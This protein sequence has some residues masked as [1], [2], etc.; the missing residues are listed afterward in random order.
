[1]ARVRRASGQ[2]A[3]ALAWGA[4]EQTS[5]MTAAMSDAD[6]QRIARS[7]MPPLK[8]AE[9]LALFDAGS[10][11]SDAFLLP[12]R[13]DLPALRAQG[14]PP[15][16]LR[17]LIKTPKRRAAAQSVAAEGL[18]AELSRLGPDARLDA[19]LNLVATEVAAVLG[20]GSASEVDRTRTFQGLGFDSLTAVELRNRLT[21]STGIRLPATL[22]FD[23]PTAGALASYLLDELFGADV[24]VPE[25]VSDNV[26]DDPIVIVGMACR[27]PGGVSSP[28]D[29]WRL[30]FEE[31][32]GVTGFPENRGWDLD[33]L[34]DSDPDAAGKTHVMQGGFLYDAPS[35]DPDFFGMSPREAL[36]TDVQHRLL[37][38]TAWEAFERAGI[39]PASVRGSK[40]GVFAGVMS[41]DYSTLVSDDIFE[42]YQGTGTAQ[43][44]LSG[45]VA[46]T[47]G[48][49]GPAVTVD[50][51]CSSSLVALHLASS[52]LRNGEC[53]LALA[54]GV[55]VMSTPGSFV[56]FSKQRGL[57]MDGRCKSFADAADGTGWGEG[58]GLLVLERQ[59]DALRNG[60]TILAVVRGSAVNQDGASN[61]LTAPNG[62][63][64]QRVIRSALASA[65]LSVA[66]VDV[67]EAHGTGT[68][69]G[70]PIE[71]Q[72][73]LAVYGQDR[74]SPLLLGSIKSNIGHT[75]AAAG[76][77]GIIKM[78]HAMRHGVVPATLHVDQPST[79]IDWTAGDVSLVTTAV[80]WPNVS[81]SR[82]AGVSSFG[83]SGTN[84][85]V[86][87]E[88]PELSD[89]PEMIGMGG[90]SPQGASQSGSIPL[91][92]SAR[93]AD[94]LAAQVE[95]I[96]AWPGDA[97]DIAFSLLTTRAVFDHRAVVL[98]GEVLASGV[99]KAGELA[100][101]FSGQG[102]QRIGMGRALYEAFPVFAEGLDAVLANL[103]PA[104]REVMWGDDQET[105]NQTGYTQPA[106][107]AFQVALYRLF[108]FYGVKPDHIAGHSIG[109]IA[110]AHV[111]GV[112]SL[113]DACQL[114][115]ARASLMQALP[116]G[117]AM[118]SVV[119]SE[120]K[121]REHLTDGVS[122]AVVN[123]PR[124]VVIAGVEEEV[125][126]IAQKWKNKRLKVSH[127]FHSPLMQPML[128]DF[129]EAI[130]GLTF[131][132]PVVQMS[133]SGDVTTVDY[134]V[135]HVRDTVRFHENVTRLGDVKFLE[136]GPDGVL[137]AMV[138]GCVP[139]VRR[140]VD[141][142]KSMLTALSRINVDGVNV[143]WNRFC[144]HGRKI[145]LPTYAFEQQTFWPEVSTRSDVRSAGLGAVG[146]PLFGAAVELAG[147][148]GL[149]FTSRLSLRTH[150]WLRDHSLHGK[151]LV[152][153]AALVEL[154][155]RA[156]DEVGLDRLDELTIAAPLV[157]PE[158]GAVQVQI[159][160]G[161]DGDR[162]AVTIHSRPEDSDLP[163]TEHAAGFLASGT[164][165]LDFD[166]SEWPPAGAEAVQVEGVYE[167]FA[168]LGFDYGHAFRG[169]RAA[170]KLGDQVF[171]EVALPEDV[172]V[173]GFGL[174]PALL[175]AALH[176]VRSRT[177]G[178]RARCRSRGKALH[179][180]RWGP[181]RCG[182]VSGPPATARWRSPSPTPPVRRSRRSGRW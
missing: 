58:V 167:R 23:Y 27:Y 9:G 56:A 50:T 90:S 42:G 88:A 29:L 26:S 129:R 85:H 154:A 114:V 122:I 100:F 111:A 161:A 137:S 80:S 150:P 63:S 177:G 32:D 55:T 16:L 31:R 144:Q 102:S 87:L 47:F 139:A 97:A 70:D 11:G 4:W 89:L 103:D 41:N 33:S 15:P 148:E 62:P 86:I 6:L 118:V 37:L 59:S 104:V 135:N 94:S 14:A 182:C 68:T 130:S 13:L 141:E 79:H 72:A 36:A 74:P 145:D 138:D 30:V 61:G 83:V 113:E 45:R 119:A 28:E 112:L 147:G 95:R 125:L 126:A 92:V 124:S 123:G 171:A 136:I 24:L 39:D 176:A 164:T 153:G 109:E 169:L 73:L 48:L 67:V 76:V 46:Y 65:G 2:H 170:W 82:R 134:W 121:V 64:Q 96:K 12:L 142:V 40:T 20:H 91:V 172:T 160:V 38:Q 43:S 18:V 51:A 140:N 173:A 71:A 181:R 17:G 110:A 77:A 22:I 115:T 60:H 152:P 158:T 1:M 101:L 34:Y 156:A 69:L 53:S 120:K 178:P 98:D 116:A 166:A 151:V 163:W 3:V 57:A 99:A 127:A 52:A 168:E 35:F 66:D 155:L 165:T 179:C 78:V 128:D 105:L 132:E 106:L 25:V 180:T 10:A 21:A 133:T 5:G 174:H 81:R 93:S 159:R 143:D 146:H 7:G 8:V 108:E 19:L 107:F 117:G 131:H 49:E 157:L 162:R 149:L 84:A 175:D 54:G 75:Q 44:V